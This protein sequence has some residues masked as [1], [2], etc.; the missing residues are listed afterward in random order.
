MKANSQRS[1]QRHKVKRIADAKRWA[2]ANPEKRSAIMCFENAKRRSRK[3]ANG[4]RGFTKKH[5]RDLLRRCG[6]LCVY[7]RTA[8][9]N[10]V[11][12]F[13]PL[14]RG[15]ADDYANIVPACRRCNSLKRESEPHS[16]IEKT[17]GSERLVF[18][19]WVMLP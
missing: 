1:Y 2:K 9:A 3:I 7:C 5:W 12:H 18:V 11:D 6:G 16:W 13:C 15:G 8:P 14:S 17:H 10:S 19:L 4:G